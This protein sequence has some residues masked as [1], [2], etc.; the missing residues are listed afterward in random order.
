MRTTIYVNELQRVRVTKEGMVELGSVN[1][2]EDR[3]MLCLNN[4][5]LADLIGKLQLAETQ[6]GVDVMLKEEPC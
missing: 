6:R 1:T 2:W 4:E 3:L 5:S